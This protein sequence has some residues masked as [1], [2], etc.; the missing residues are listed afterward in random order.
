ME[1]LLPC[2]LLLPG[3]LSYLHDSILIDGPLQSTY[4]SPDVFI[5]CLV[6]FLIANTPHVAVQGNS[7]HFDHVQVGVTVEIYFREK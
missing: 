2:E 4:G 1:E 3:H 7:F 5:L 6:F